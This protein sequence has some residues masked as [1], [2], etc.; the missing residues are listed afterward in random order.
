M[1]N[2]III[3]ILI[4]P[5]FKINSQW[6]TQSS[7][8]V[9]NLRSIYFINSE[10][11]YAAGEYG[12][13]YKTVNGGNNWDTITT[14][15]IRDINSLHFFNEN[16]GIACANDGIIIRTSDS[17]INWTTIP[18]GVTGNL[19]AVSFS[20][21]RGVCAGGDGTLLYSD[22]S[23][24]NWTIA[25]NGFFVIYY[26]ADMFSESI[27]YA[28]GVNTIF[29]PFV[30]K[31]VNGGS[32]WNFTNFYLNGNEGDLTDVCFISENNGFATSA[33][34]N[35]Q[36]GISRT[37]DGGSNWTTQL[38]ERQLYSIDFAGINTGYCVGLQGLILKT[39]DGGLSWGSQSGTNNTL[40]S[41]FFTDSLTGYAAGDLG[42]IIKTTNGGLT[43]IIDPEEVIPGKYFLYQN[44]PNPFNPITTIRY[45]LP[46]NGFVTLKIYN[47]LGSEV[48]ELVNETQSDGFH[49]VKFDGSNL[50]GGI[51][52]YKFISGEFTEVRKLVLIK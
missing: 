8:T 10:T 48:S 44:Y 21:T 7:G 9:E 43:A 34:F 13:M 23:G 17:G 12:K 14:G 40:R 42:T 27:S 45:F 22:N 5:F 41:V 46:V 50:A 35:G 52:Y 31:S 36:G 32:N 24:L 4:I 16:T 38:F 1:R 20:G 26:G 18:S 19:Y 49:N 3:L 33:V 47:T 37:T 25:E 11:G 29:Q 51:Y 28:A 15:I 6:I 39:T 30:A 2:K